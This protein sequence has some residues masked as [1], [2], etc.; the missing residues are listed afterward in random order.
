M[1]QQMLKRWHPLQH[2]AGLLLRQ[3]GRSAGSA[4][5]YTPC[6]CA[7]GSYQSNQRDACGIVARRMALCLAALYLRLCWLAQSGHLHK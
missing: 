4:C 2:M 6:R 7:S 1:D 3:R 5:T